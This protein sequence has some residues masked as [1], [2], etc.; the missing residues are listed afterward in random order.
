M[1]SLVYLLSRILPTHVRAMLTGV[2]K[3]EITQVFISVFILVILFGTTT[4]LCSAVTSISQSVAQP[5]PIVPSVNSTVPFPALE[6]PNVTTAAETGDP[7][8]FAESY[9]GNY[10]FNIGPNLAIQTYAYSYSF[11]ILSAIWTQAGSLISSIVGDFNPVNNAALGPFQVNVSFPVGI[12]LGVA[13]GILS[14]LFLDV[15]SPLII[16]GIGIMLLQ[17]L[18]LVISQATAFVLILPVALVMRSI[19]FSGANLRPAANSLLA[20]AIAL[21]IIYPLMI[22]F[23]SYVLHWMFTPCNAATQLNPLSCNPSA[24]YLQYTYDHDNLEGVLGNQCTATSFSIFGLPIAVPSCGS[25]LGYLESLPGVLANTFSAIVFYTGDETILGIQY[26]LLEISEFMFIVIVMFAI[27]ITVT[28]GFAMGLTRALNGG[29][30]GAA[31]FWS[32]I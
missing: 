25:A 28:L 29:I 10:A 13:Y 6:T 26:I 15:L 20:I 30:E 3:I 8:A 24:L 22:V 7:F 19:A 5:I 32:N 23:N 9:T 16:L 14:A 4:Y 27:D 21:Y 2:T 18:F 1:I 11:A 31:S 17:Y 12:D